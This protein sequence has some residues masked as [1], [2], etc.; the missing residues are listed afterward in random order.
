MAGVK[1]GINDLYTW[2]KNNGEYGEQVRSEFTGIGEDGRHYN[3]NGIA[4]Q[5]NKR[6]IWKCKRGHTWTIGVQKRTLLGSKC[7]HCAGNTVTKGSNDLYTWCIQNNRKDL[8]EQFVGLDADGKQI[9]MTELARASHKKVFWEHIHNGKPHRWLAAISDR[10]SNNSGCP[11]CNGKNSIKDGENDLY[12]WCQSNPG[13]GDILIRQWLGVTVDG[14][15]VHMNK[16]ARGTSKT[17]LLWM[18]DCGEVWE[19]TPLNR[20]YNKTRMCPKCAKIE[21]AKIRYNTILNN[22]KSLLEWCKENGLRGETLLNE[23]CGVDENGKRISA[24]NITYRSKCRVWWEHY[25]KHGEHH[26]WLAMISGRT[27]NN[28]N[29]PYCNTQGTSL[30]EQIIYRSFKQVY[31]DTLSRQKYNGYEIDISIP[32]INLYIEYGSTYY[33]DGREERDRQKEDM[34]INNGWQFI[35]IID[36]KS[37]D[38]NTFINHTM[39]IN[40]AKTSIK[41]VINYIF[42][43]YK[44]DGIPD[45]DKAII[46]AKDYILKLK[47]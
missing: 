34:C 12:T 15:L 13:L 28:S 24:D 41:D 23:F 20:I 27:Y 18:C 33:H 42:K 3:I 45:I 30:N 31:P 22:S 29:C 44:L 32:S 2:C 16:I 10:T 19:S 14:K 40:F 8:I 38:Q 1:V 7:P 37:V 11:I 39:R 47:G 25:T 6:L 5:S 43:A 26:T 46:E 35:N 36:D 17:R 4:A 9:K 21:G